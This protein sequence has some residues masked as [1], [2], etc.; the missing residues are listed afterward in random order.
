MDEQPATWRRAIV[1]GVAGLGIV[2]A[3]IVAVVVI[4]VT[5]PEAV[6]EGAVRRTA[7]LVETAPVEHGTFRPT[8]RALGAVRPFEEIA[9]EARVTGHV[10]GVEDAFV[11]GQVVEKGD[12]LL[13][14]DPADARNAL[15]QR[16]SALQQAQAA[17]TLE[18]GRQAVA[19]LERDQIA[20]QLE[21][22]I[23]PDQEALILREPQL[24]S[25]R[26]AV[27]AAEAAVRQAELDLTR[28]DVV[29]PFRALVLERSVHTGALIRPGTVLGRLVGVDRFW[30]E[31]TLPTGRL[32]H[33]AD[34]PEL[35][36]VLRD[37]SG[38]GPDA[39]R[40]GTLQSVIG[41]LD[42]TTRAAR[43]LVSVADPLALD[44][45]TSGPALLSGAWVEADLPGRV[46]SDVARV[47]RPWLRRHQGRDALWLMVDGA[48]RVHP[49][50][51]LV[52]DAEHA[53]LDGVPTDARVVTTDLATVSDGA[54]LREAR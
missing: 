48:L 25:A 3:T 17:L 8:L 32:R 40:E 7:M 43:V 26:A 53:Y 24:Q 44:P 2:L 37:P 45:D 42:E 23:T 51:L 33:L 39:R 36:V 34:D 50:D 1:T 52:E 47:P 28:T 38:W 54:P 12:R 11:P 19:A 9:V 22:T 18:R 15:A 5:E 27:Q 30:V 35:P 10:T 29:A 49:V 31:L 46:L 16:R 4:Q 13:R 41:Q 6:R 21:G 14:I 20:Q